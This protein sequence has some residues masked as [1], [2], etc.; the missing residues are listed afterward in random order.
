[1]IFVEAPH[2][3]RGLISL[4]LIFAQTPGAE[5]GRGQNHN[6]PIKK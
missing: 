3:E 2:M 5:K 1:M 4:F 6:G